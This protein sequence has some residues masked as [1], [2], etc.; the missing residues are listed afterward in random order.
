MSYRVRP[1]VPAIPEANSEPAVVQP[2]GRTPQP[3]PL[4]PMPTHFSRPIVP[5]PLPESP[6]ARAVDY[7]W[8]VGRLHHDARRGRWSVCYSD[9]TTPDRY[10]GVLELIGTGP[11]DGFH[12]GQFVRVEGKLIDPAPLETQPAYRVRALQGVI[13]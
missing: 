4:P 6:Y 1:A 3:R 8:L 11:M 13:H 10:G 7:Q 2:I 9:G 12:P 5:T